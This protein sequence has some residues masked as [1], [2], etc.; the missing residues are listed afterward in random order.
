M[1]RLSK[2]LVDESVLPGESLDIFS[3]LGDLCCL[4]LGKLSLLIEVFPKRANLTVEVLDLL[5]PLEELSLEVIFLA[6][7]NRH[8]VLHVGEFEDLLL[9]LVLNID[10]FLCLGVELTLH[11]IKV[12][13]QHG[14]RL[15]QVGD[16]A[17]LAKDFLLVTLHVV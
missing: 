5:L 3:Q 17:L 6:S 2:L 4:Q 11:I 15:L 14:N 1:G 10:E 12:S 8:L 13:V 16:L 9:E 7:G